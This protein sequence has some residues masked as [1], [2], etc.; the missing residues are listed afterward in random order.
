MGGLFLSLVNQL[1]N[2][3]KSKNLSNKNPNTLSD[4]RDKYQIHAPT[5]G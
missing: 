3:L 2:N 1:K 4:N 5:S